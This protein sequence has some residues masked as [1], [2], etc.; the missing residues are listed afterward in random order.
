MSHVTI[1]VIGL[2]LWTCSSAAVPPSVPRPL[3]QQVERLSQLLKDRHAEWY[4]DAT[5][6]QIVKSGAQ[7][8]LA[9][10]VFT[11]EGLGGGNNHNQYFA[12][13][14]VN[15]EDKFSPAYTL[16]DV[17]RVGG[18]GWR[19]VDK[20]GAR[21]AQTAKGSDLAIDIDA[22]EVTP[23][24]APNFPTRKIVIHLLLRDGRLSEK[25][26]WRSQ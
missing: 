5:M 11:V 24:D 7:R 6:V 16:V 26:R 17:M 19:A 10:V 25:G 20:L 14:D 13:F 9:L 1:F 2:L 22:L 12:V 21:L 18:K 15:R 4:S 23:K 3:A 8:E